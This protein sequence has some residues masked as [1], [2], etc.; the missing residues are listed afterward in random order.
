M[1]RVL[2][3][4]LPSDPGHALWKRDFRGSTGLFGVE[5]MPCTRAQLAAFIDPLELFALG[6][7]WGGYES[8]VV[9][10]HMAHARTVR[11]W[12]GGPLVR[13]HIGLE[14]PH[15]LLEDLER[16]LQRLKSA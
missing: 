7:S 9:T 4:A 16:G 8:L 5:L 14:D 1:R 12:T 2:H 3:P 6:Y 10:A 13:L 11:R 15:D